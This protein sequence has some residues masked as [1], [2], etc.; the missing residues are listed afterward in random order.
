MD[1]QKKKKNLHLKVTAIM[2]NKPG[3]NFRKK[4]PKFLFADLILN[5]PVSTFLVQKRSYKKSKR[6]LWVELKW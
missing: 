6:K 2:P 3:Q 1:C 4:N 5:I